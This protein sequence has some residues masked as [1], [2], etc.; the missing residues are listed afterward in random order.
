MGQSGPDAKVQG[1][2]VEPLRMQIGQSRRY[3]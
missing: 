3:N 2:Q 1:I